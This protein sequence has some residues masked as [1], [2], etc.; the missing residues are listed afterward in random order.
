MSRAELQ[1]VLDFILNRADE[2]EF[3]V[4]RKACERRNRDGAF[5]AIGSSSSTVMAKKMAESVETTM[6]SS[7]ESV[8]SMSRNFVADLIRKQE[9]GIGD[10]ELAALVEHYLPS[11][12]AGRASPTGGPGEPGRKDDSGREGS[13]TGRAADFG[14]PAE[15]L[16]AMA[17]DFVSY[18]EG[19][20]APSRQKELWDE[21]PRW[22]D[23]YWKALPPEIKA[24]VK[25]Y[26]EGT[27]DAKTFTSALLSLLEL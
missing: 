11:G 18:S 12:A 23:E 14:L 6:G 26:L 8:R 24:I 3:E 21:M 15:M 9:P 5:A 16:L 20:M 10:E 19:T 2:K 7:L 4:I 25:A 13:T 22:Q 1:K 27:I 17:R